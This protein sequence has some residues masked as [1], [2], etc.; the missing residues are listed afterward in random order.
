MDS[1][2]A[3]VA[4]LAGA[5]VEFPGPR[6]RVASGPQCRTRLLVLSVSLV[7]Q[8]ARQ[9]L[10]LSAERDDPL[11]PKTP[12]MRLPSEAGRPEAPRKSRTLLTTLEVVAR[13]TVIAHSGPEMATSNCQHQDMST[14]E[15]QVQGV[16]SN[17]VQPD[18]HI[19][20]SEEE[21][22]QSRL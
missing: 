1:L 7:L 22:V 8:P 6:L 14:Q 9:L 17:V 19:F 18:G 13:H 2:S 15:V 21:P 3:D 20:A 10:S 5:A 4:L 11:Q 16:L 12:L